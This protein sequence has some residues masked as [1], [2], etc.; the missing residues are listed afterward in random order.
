MLELPSHV[1]VKFIATEKDCN[2]LRDLIGKPII[3]M[4]SE[5]R[6]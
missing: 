4:D 2:I 5:W 3:G 1:R 6:P